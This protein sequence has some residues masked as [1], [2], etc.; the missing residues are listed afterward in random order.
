MAWSATV[1]FT[2]DGGSVRI[3]G[4][5]LG[6]SQEEAFNAAERI[7]VSMSKSGELC[8]LA[9]VEPAEARIE[10]YGEMIVHSIS[11]SFEIKDESVCH[12]SIPSPAA[13]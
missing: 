12:R 8:T 10:N 7:W 11:F 5:I 4:K 3:I 2:A 1:N 6:A 13:R 9:K